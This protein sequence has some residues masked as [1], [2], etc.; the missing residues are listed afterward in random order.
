MAEPDDQRN[1]RETARHRD[2]ETIDGAA[3]STPK[4]DRDD[5]AYFLYSL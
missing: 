4:D 3:E 2:A 1:D 5:V